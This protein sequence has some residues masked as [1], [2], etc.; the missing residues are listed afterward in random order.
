MLVLT[1]IKYLFTQGSGKGAEWL[2]RKDNPNG[3][4]LMIEQARIDGKGQNNEVQV[5]YLKWRLWIK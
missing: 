1:D 5:W 2:D 3:F 4:F